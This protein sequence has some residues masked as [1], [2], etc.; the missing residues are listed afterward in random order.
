MVV[1]GMLVAR[2]TERTAIPVRVRVDDVD[3]IVQGLRAQHNEHRT[4]DLLPVINRSTTSNS[5]RA[6]QRATHL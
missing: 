4:E 5:M 2:Q 1:R 6:V 3:G